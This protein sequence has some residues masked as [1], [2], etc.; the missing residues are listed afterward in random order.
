MCANAH[1]S[2]APTAPQASQQEWEHVCGHTQASQA[3]V[4]AGALPACRLPPGGAPGIAGSMQQT[5]DAHLKHMRRSSSAGTQWA[6][7]R[8]ATPR[9]VARAS[10]TRPAQT[11]RQTTAVV[12]ERRKSSRALGRSKRG[13][14]CP[15][16]P[17][18]PQHISTP[19]HYEL[20]A[21]PE[22]SVGPQLPCQAKA[23]CWRVGPGEAAKGQL[24]PQGQ[25]RW[26]VG[27]RSRECCPPRPPYPPSVC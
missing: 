25:W 6:G 10:R 21:T 18:A 11:A 1:A 3:R 13:P 15:T 12:Y 16:H 24:A 5:A 8:P 17:P 2:P 22:V 7:K 26:Q 19:A 20:E 9:Q 4:R 14:R 27:P 23:W